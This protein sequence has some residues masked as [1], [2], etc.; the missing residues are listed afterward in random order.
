MRQDF[1]DSTES[2][3][4]SHPTNPTAIASRPSYSR[5]AARNLLSQ[6]DSKEIRRGIDTLRKRIEKHFG[7]ADEEALSQKLVGFVCKE[8]ERSYERTIDRTE[9]I[10][11][12]VYPASEGEKVVELDFA[13]ADVQAGFRR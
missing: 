7:D 9:R 8:C 2:L 3:L 12:E 11:M 1:L 13:K 6:Y 5:K 4:T 10:I